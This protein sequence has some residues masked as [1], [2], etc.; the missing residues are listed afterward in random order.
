MTEYITASA[1]KTDSG[2]FAAVASDVGLVRQNNE[3]NYLLHSCINENCKETSGAAGFIPSAPGSWK[4]ICVFDGMGG[5]AKGELAALMAA[6]DFRDAAAALPQT[7]QRE[8]ADARIRQ[9]FQTA[10][11]RVLKLRESCGAYG[12]TAVAICTDGAVFKIYHLGD[13]RAYLLRKGE[14]FQLSRD[15]TLAEMKIRAGLYRAGDPREKADRHRL[16][17]YV[18]GDGTGENAS[19][20]ESQW[21]TVKPEDSLLLCSDGLYEMC[22]DPE[23]SSI[24]NEGGDARYKAEKLVALARQ[25]G[26]MDNITCACVDFA[27]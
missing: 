23:I 26:G 27:K 17:E 16:T 18:G 22:T 24:L 3:D 7:H 20:E 19:P 10:N 11:N 8:G 1:E 25:K 6:Q 9:A 12:T 14:L 5:G 13:S 4:M 15:H 2:F 21:I